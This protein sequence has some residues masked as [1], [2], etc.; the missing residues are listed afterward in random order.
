M[1]FHLPKPLHGW[2]EFAGEIAIIVVGVLIALTAEQVVEAV[3]WHEQ[4]EAGREA[5]RQDFIT[6]VANAREREGEDGCIRR[7]LSEVVALLNASPGVLPSIGH[8]GSPPARPWYPASWD[9]LVASGVSAHMPRE[10]MLAFSSIASS[11]RT[12]QESTEQ[13]LLEW[14]TIY[15]IVGPARRLDV[16]EAGQ[17]RRAI[18][19]A[20]YRLNLIRLGGPQVVDAIRRT[21][22]LTPDDE[23]EIERQL[24][25]VREGANWQAICGPI[26]PVSGRIVEAPYDPAI[27]T[28][29]LGSRGAA[30]HGG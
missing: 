16:G 20:L 5:L 12:R 26:Q 15:T 28:D 30:S 27:Q 2:R 25:S 9:S 3:H 10:E 14:A 1:H 8:L 22:L 6:I 29:P 13:E 24:H 11:A 7:R 21:G 18:A 23:M 17:V 19:N 4:V